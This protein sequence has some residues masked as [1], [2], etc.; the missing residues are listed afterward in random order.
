[1]NTEYLRNTLIAFTAFS[2]ASSAVYCFN[3]I[4]DAGSDKLDEK[5]KNRPIAS[6]E[7]SA[8]NAYIL[9]AILILMSLAVIFRSG[10]RAIVAVI[11]Y[12]L[13]NVAYS[14]KI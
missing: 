9:Y 1:M 4:C 11:G 5:R 6:G 12:I 2:L 10:L 8:K 14:L 3:D 13:I 7:I